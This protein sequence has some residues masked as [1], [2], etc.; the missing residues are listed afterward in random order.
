MHMH[1]YM[2]IYIHMVLYSRAHTNI[3]SGRRHWGA[4]ICVKSSF[5]WGGALHAARLWLWHARSQ[6]ARWAGAIYTRA[7]RDAG[8]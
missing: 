6:C 5:L 7:W 1:A 2:H 3:N 4:A 8:G